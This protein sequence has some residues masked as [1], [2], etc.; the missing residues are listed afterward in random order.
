MSAFRLRTLPIVHDW[1]SRVVKPGDTVI[2]ATVGNGHDTLFLADLVGPAGRVY[3]F[4]IQQEAVTRTAAALAQ[5]GLEGAASLHAC[6][7][8]TLQEYVS[9]EVSACMFNLGYLPSGDK[10]IITQAQST[11][12]ALEQALQLLA[13]SGLI[14]IMCY[15][16][17]DGGQSECLAVEAW[18][19]SLPTPDHLVM[20]V[21]PHNTIKAAPY[22]LAIQRNKNPLPQS[23]DGV[24]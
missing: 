8:S 10:S 2:D 20:K 14:T 15:P 6:C 3:G 16:G 11:I 1:V 24:R 5:A 12:S 7:H 13:A 4:D 23:P 21:Q 22:L 17:H 9:G 18:A 19:Q